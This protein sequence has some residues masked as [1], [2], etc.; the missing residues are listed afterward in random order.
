MENDYRY[1]IKDQNDNY[2]K[3]YLNMKNNYMCLQIGGNKEYTD[4][5]LENLERM[6][7]PHY[8]EYGVGKFI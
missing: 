4:N 1:M 2:D 8:G 5:D 3:K 7:D 6:M